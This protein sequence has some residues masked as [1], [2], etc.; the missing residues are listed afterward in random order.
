MFRCASILAILASISIVA[1]AEVSGT[2]TLTATTAL[3]LDTGVTSTSGGDLLWNGSTLVP[4]GTAGLFNFLTSGDTGP[5]LFAS[6]TQDTLSKLSTA[7]YTKTG[8]GGASAVAGSVY[9]V[10]TNG[11]NYAKILVTSNSG[12]S[13]GLQF[14]TFTSSGGGTPPGGGG[15]AGTAPTITAVENAATNIP[16]GV[17]NSPIAQGSLFVVKGSNLGPASVAIATAF[18]LTT[19]IGGT[20][21]KVTVNGTTVDAIMYYSLAAQVAAILPS[22]TPTGTGTLT[23]SYNGQS[24]SAPIVVT[25]SNIGIFTVSQSG[26]GDAIVFLNSDNGLIT[27]THAVNVGDVVIFWGTGLGPVSSDETQPA[28]QSD[29]TNVPLQVFIGGKQANVLFRGRSSCC[30]SVDVIAVTVP[31]GLSGCAVSV[32]MQIGNMISNTTSIAT[33]SNGRTCTPLSSTTPTGVTGT[34]PYRFGG[35]VLERIVETTSTGSSTIV[36]KSD[37]A[38]GI[39]EKVTPSSTAA[40]TGAQIDVNSYGS[41]TVSF[42]TGNT[43]NTGSN[44]GTVQYLDA[45]ASIA[46]AA[47]FGNR[48][49]VKS[50]PGGGITLYSATLDQTATTLAPGVYTFTGPGGADVGA[51]TANYTMPAPFV[52]TNQANITTVTRSSGLNITWTGGDPAGYVTIAGSSTAFGTTA[53]TTTTVGFTCTAR[54]SDGNFSVPPIVLL[55]LPA[56]AAAPGGTVVVPGALAVTHIGGATSFNPP[57]GID[58]ASIVSVFEFGGTVLYQ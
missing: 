21:I 1:S 29:M 50:S 24:A 53:A 11:G 30:S 37:S 17:P 9:G 2:K 8:V 25:Q 48:T 52:W 28:V 45:G 39:F 41:C 44:T 3:N 7:V 36:S 12:G 10:H 22:K 54:V 35:I 5:L 57:S 51:F 26:T 34:A 42:R 31:D 15:G 14:V 23:V 20:S 46:M 56:S 58:F 40:P 6:I 27:P 43:G 32:N 19:S 47:P 4:Q 18:P 55:G 49:L 33:A 13:L 16:P 38:T